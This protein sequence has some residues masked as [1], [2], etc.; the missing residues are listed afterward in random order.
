MLTIEQQIEAYADKIP[1]IQKRFTVGNIV[2]YPYQAVAYIETAKRI[3]KYE[4]P[5]YIKASV[6]AGKTIMIAMLAAQCKAMN[7]P[8]MVLARQ[9]EIVKQDSEEISNLDVPNSVYCAGL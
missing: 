4:P 7:L 9:A 1:L 5:F 2:P 6:S 3:A 8:M